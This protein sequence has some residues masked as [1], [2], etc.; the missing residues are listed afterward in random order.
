MKSFMMTPVQFGLSNIVIVIALMGGRYISLGTVRYHSGALAYTVGALIVL[1]A[2]IIFAVVLIKGYENIYALLAGIMVFG[3]GFGALAPVGM[4]SS[5]TAFRETSGMA[6]S[7]QGCLVLGG[8]A[9]GSGSV[10]LVLNN[11]PGIS[12]MAVFAVFVGVLSLLTFISAIGVRN[13]LV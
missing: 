10:A 3:L 2:G 13:K 12:P 9:I 8:T 7:L 5:I 4:K 11:M 6:A 1:T